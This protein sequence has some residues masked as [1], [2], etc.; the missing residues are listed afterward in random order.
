MSIR[1]FFRNKYHFVK[2][3]CIIRIIRLTCHW[4][5]FHGLYSEAASRNI[6]SFRKYRMICQRK[7]FHKSSENPSQRVAAHSNPMLYTMI[8]LYMYQPISRHQFLLILSCAR[9]YG[10]RRKFHL[11]MML[12]WEF[13]WEPDIWKDEEMR[14]LRVFVLKI[15][16]C[17]SRVMI[18]WNIYN[19]F[20]PRR[21]YYFKKH[22]VNLF[23]HII[24][25]FY[26]FLLKKFTRKH[27]P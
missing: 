27:G 11:G 18:F 4:C 25:I 21:K 13:L 9:I 7:S 12:F 23:L 22:I 10:S 19:V 2:Y 15:R 24:K 1:T 8:I 16:I 26:Q 6:I 17:S 14:Y 3:A 20:F 5:I